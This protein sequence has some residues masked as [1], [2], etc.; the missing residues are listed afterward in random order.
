MRLQT[1]YRISFLI[2][3]LVLIGYPLQAQDTTTT[4]SQSFSI[5]KGKILT[6]FSIDGITASR[7]NY[8]HEFERA[9]SRLRLNVE[10][11]YFINDRIGFGPIIG[12]EYLYRDYEDPTNFFDPEDQWNYSLLY[13]A[14]AGW[15]FPIEKLFDADKLRENNRL[16]NTLLFIN[17]GINWLWE[18]YR[19]EERGAIEDKNRF[20]YQ[21]NGGLLVPVGKQIL[22]E[23]M[24]GWE[25]RRQQYR[26]GI[27]EDGQITQEFEETEWLKEL[28][29]GLGLKVTF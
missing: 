19:I 17:G 8:N 15:Y 13:G 6:G 5:S 23:W 2:I 21:L 29:V 25:A 18:R 16:Q 7:D 22:L 3:L 14:K 28:S 11:L 27:I 1:S 20:G 26:Y 4:K 24:L 10:G 12:Y 9:F